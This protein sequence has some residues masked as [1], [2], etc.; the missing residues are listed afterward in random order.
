MSDDL[1][2]LDLNDL[3]A[4]KLREEVQRLRVSNAVVA[5]TLVHRQEAL[6]AVIAEVLAIVEELN[7]LPDDLSGDLAHSDASLCHQVLTNWTTG[8]LASLAEAL[9]GKAGD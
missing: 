7:T 8:K 5:R 3:K 2:T 1:E 9:R 6:Y 4:E